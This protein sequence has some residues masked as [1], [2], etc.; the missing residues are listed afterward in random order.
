MGAL[1]LGSE[2][3]PLD[4]PE[5]VGRGEDHREGR[6]HCERAAVVPAGKR[7]QHLA[8]EAAEPWQPEAG[9]KHGHGQPAI[10]RHPIEDPAKLLEI[11][12]VDPVVKH[13][14][15]EKHAGRRDAVSQHLEHRP[16]YSLGPRIPAELIA[17][18]RAP[19]AEAEHHV[20]HVAHRTVGHHPL[21]VFLG[22]RG[23][24]AVHH[25]HHAE[26]TH[27]PSKR[28]AGTRADRIADPQ[29]AVAAELEEHAS[30]DHRNRCR[31][32][33][34][35]VGQP[36]MHRHDRHLD[37]ESDQQQ[38]EGPDLEAHAPEAD[39]GEGRLR[40]L[41]QLGES[42]KI[43]RMDRA[44]RRSNRGDGIGPAGGIERGT[45]DVARHELL[46]REHPQIAREIEHQDR[47]QH[48]HAAEQRVEEELDRRVLPTRS[49]P[50]AD[51]EVHGEEH[52][53]PEDVE[54]KEIERH[55][56][57][58]HARLEQQEEH[59]VGLHVLRDRPT[60]RTCQHREEGGQHDQ[61]HTDPVDA[62]QIV[63]VEGWDPRLLHHALHAGL[64]DSELRGANGPEER[65]PRHPERE[66]K[67][68]HRGGERH[69]ADQ[70]FA[71]L[72]NDRQ[73]E[74]R[75]DERR[76]KHDHR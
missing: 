54:E 69:P 65:R 18:N 48:Q 12:V 23:E 36:R 10:D 50:D 73:R 68:H 59:V 17:R 31:G 72:G 38:K 60:R 76:Q 58:Q 6:D 53:L 74:H 4:R 27:E 39:R 61:R 46:G 3:H 15:H 44:L 66:H 30:Q 49:A 20:A 34:V 33:D 45:H 21:E 9:E 62:E 25:R 5:T 42:Q 63:D 47:Q 51:Q 8:D 52:H 14:H 2:I 28:E 22:E 71:A 26:P 75:G 64:A 40:K 13:S 32:L 1:V 57:A 55:E 24:R 37:H 67:N 70:L 41:A 43:E 11:A 56:H 19:Y 16:V 7:D 35:S 29:D